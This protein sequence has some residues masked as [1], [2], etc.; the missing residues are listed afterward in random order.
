MGK[1]WDKVVIDRD[2]FRRMIAQSGYT[3]AGLSREAGYDVSL[4]SRM[5]S[6]GSGNYM[7]LDEFCTRCN[8]RVEDVMA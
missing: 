6:Q 1:K 3:L 4:A 7:T 5:L 8:R 2:E